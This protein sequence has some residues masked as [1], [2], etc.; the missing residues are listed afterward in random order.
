MS[1]NLSLFEDG[2]LK[3]LFLSDID[4]GDSEAIESIDKKLNDE[5][6]SMLKEIVDLQERI[7]N[8][9]TF[10]KDLLNAVGKGTMQYIDAM[11]DTGDTFIDNKDPFA[12]RNNDLAVDKKTSL[13]HLLM[14][15]K[16]VHLGKPTKRFL[17][18]ILLIA[19]RE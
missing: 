7:N 3:V 19:L 5:E 17:T 4:C 6:E 12:S 15:G 13:L 14:T 8:S 18:K 9:S 11:T 1:G 16:L 10:M 2:K